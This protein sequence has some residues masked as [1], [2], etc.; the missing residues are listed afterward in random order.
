MGN[1]LLF[2]YR[3]SWAVEDSALLYVAVPSEE[4]AA[5]LEQVIKSYPEDSETSLT[6]RLKEKRL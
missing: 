3:N 5:F 6:M 4:K 1:F 2:E